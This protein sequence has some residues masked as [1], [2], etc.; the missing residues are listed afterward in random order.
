M[1]KE[2]SCGIIPLRKNPAGEYEVLVIQ[3]NRGGHRSFPKG[4]V[5]EWE[6]FL[7]TAIRECREETGLE[8]T[9]IDQK[10]FHDQHQFLRKETTIDKHVYYFVGMTL[11]NAVT[12]EEREIKN[13]VRLSLQ[14]VGSQLTFPSD[15]ELWTEVYD[16][17]LGK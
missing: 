14:K 5:E 16:Y 10:Q 3:H 1:T 6:T 9:E 13:Y 17:L 8:F 2:I 4:H 15:K 7:Q 11:D 12:K